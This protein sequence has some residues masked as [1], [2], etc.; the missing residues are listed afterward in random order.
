MREEKTGQ[1]TTS[2]GA[3]TDKS[4]ERNTLSPKVPAE[5]RTDLLLGLLGSRPVS[6][7]R[8]KDPSPSPSLVRDTQRELGSNTRREPS[9]PPPPPP[10]ERR[11]TVRLEA[12]NV[13]LA[14]PPDP[15]N[16][17]G[18]A[19]QYQASS[20][21]GRRNHNNDQIVVWEPLEPGWPP[22]ALSQA[23]AYL[24]LKLPPRAVPEAKRLLESDMLREFTKG[25]IELLWTARAMPFVQGRHVPLL[26]RCVD[27]SNPVR[28]C[29]AIDF[30]NNCPALDFVTALSLLDVDYANYT[31]R[32]FAV[33][34]LASFAAE[35]P[36]AV[37]QLTQAL[38]YEPYHDSALTRLLVAAAIAQ[39]LSFGHHL[40]WSLR[41]EME[42]APVFRE[43]YAL[44]LEEFLCFSP[45]PA[46]ELSKQGRV[47]NALA[48]CADMVLVWKKEKLPEEEIEN[49]YHAL[50]SHFNQQVLAK[51]PN[52]RF[53]L[54]LDPRVE[55]KGLIV[56]RCRYMSSKKVPL[57]LV[58]ENA[59]P[60]G[61]PI[62]LLF[63]TG[64]D[65]RQDMLTLQLLSYMD[66]IWLQKGLHMHIS[67]Y[68]A[69]ATGL[70]ETG[71]YLGMIQAVCPANTTSGIQMEFGKSALKGAYK[72]EPLND[73]IRSHNPDAKQ[74]AAAVERFT[75]SC[76]GY[77]VA[78]YVLG[79]GDRHNGNIMVKPDGMLFHIDF[80]HF[81]GNF[82]TK[83]GIRRERTPFVFTQ[84]MAFVICSGSN[85][86]NPIFK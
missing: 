71:E 60:T 27:W 61:S 21:P 55:A 25:E 59:E 77:C 73:F 20:V 12:A 85:F 51:L 65:L 8:D 50:L 75:R 56:S 58:L 44:I 34:F 78:T 10:R 23:V 40:F 26:L 69:I 31:V 48:K 9:K 1:N 86:N 16:N 67:P 84:Q 45:W 64:D 37:L 83:M 32:K 63:K 4:L 11:E 74:Y 54:P 80:G 28:R 72:A 70:T 42:L 30:L 13:P 41:A 68:R 39:P 79:I 24:Q 47:I 29:E 15:A 57:W 33:K 62:I 43:R 17:S 5:E 76:A 3:A 35:L 7:Q 18:T 82:K 66:S 52:G 6:P 19:A 36:S 22:L 2:S 38:K 53:Q 49:K 46:L 81:L 14:H